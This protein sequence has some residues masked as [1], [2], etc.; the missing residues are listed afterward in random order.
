MRQYGIIV[1]RQATGFVVHTEDCPVYK[2]AEQNGKHTYG[3]CGEDVEAAIKS[4]CDEFEAQDQGYY[5][6][7][8]KI[9][10]CVLESEGSHE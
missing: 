7:D 8:F 9:A 2:R 3:M 10:K 5:R 6:K 1:N 4:E